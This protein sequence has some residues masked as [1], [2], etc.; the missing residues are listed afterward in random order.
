MSSGADQSCSALSSPS[1]DPKPRHGF[2]ATARSLG[3]DAAWHSPKTLVHAPIKLFA[4]QSPGGCAS[5]PGAATH[6]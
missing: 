4:G 5:R 3:G 2:E 6:V 1:L